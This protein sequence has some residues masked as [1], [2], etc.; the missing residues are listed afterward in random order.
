M[1]V[2]AFEL[3]EST[4]DSCGAAQG[5]SIFVDH[6]QMLKGNMS[7]CSDNYRIGYVG[8]SNHHNAEKG[9]WFCGPEM[10]VVQN[11]QIKPLTKATNLVKVLAEAGKALSL[12]T[13]KHVL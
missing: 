6:F 8:M 2:L 13:V 10:E 3:L 4:L 7:I 9:D 1:Y 11:V 12:F 5:W